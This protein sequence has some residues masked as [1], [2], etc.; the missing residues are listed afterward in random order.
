MPRRDFFLHLRNKKR[1]VASAPLPRQPAIS[2]LGVDTMARPPGGRVK[3][4]DEMTIQPLEPQTFQSPDMTQ[5]P[6]HLP[7]RSPPISVTPSNSRLWWNV[8]D[9]SSHHVCVLSF[10][11]GILCR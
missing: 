4:A 8:L 11:E 9:S 6:R 1:A 10:L 2:S 5:V 3:A 7:P